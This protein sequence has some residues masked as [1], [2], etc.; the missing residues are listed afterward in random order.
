LA[1][2]YTHIANE[3]VVSH[4]IFWLIWVCGFTIL[5]SFGAGFSVYGVWLVYYLVTLP[6]FIAHTYAVAYW[7][8]PRYF[9]KH[10][11]LLFVVGILIFLV[12]ASLGELIISNDLIWRWVKPE[13]IQ[14][15]YLSVQNILINGLGNEYIVIAFL[16]VK[17]VKFWNLKIGEQT[18]LMNRKLSAEVELL[19]YQSYPRFVLNVMDRLEN[20][21]ETKSPQTSEMIIRLSNLMT[22][23][24][25]GRKSDKILL[26]KEVEMIRSYIEIQR[27]S[28]PKDYQVNFL[29][30]G[31]LNGLQIPPFLF[32]QL[33]EEGFVLLENYQKKIDYTILLKTEPHF[34]LFSMTL[35]NDNAVALK[36]NPQVLKN[37]HKYLNYFYPENHKVMSNF[38]INFAELSLEIYL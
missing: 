23:M 20:L 14:P 31:E 12:V 36:F 6:L 28:F 35:W 5:Q 16:A 24:T 29:V 17:V 9:F 3:R 15:D 10:R 33:I 13:N 19:Q 27:M 25:T 2:F 8:V 34:L 38:E 7:L 22:N 32:F 18:E 4:V 11:Y 26:Q 1:R 30:T 37:C 21:A